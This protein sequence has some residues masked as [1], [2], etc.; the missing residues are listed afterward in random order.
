MKRVAFLITVPSPGLLALAIL[1]SGWARHE[2]RHRIAIQL[3]SIGA[4]ENPVWNMTAVL[5]PFQND[6]GLHVVMG[7]TCED[8][9]V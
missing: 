1:H 3:R 4:S 7:P 6:V 9:L 2:A 8:Q 5:F